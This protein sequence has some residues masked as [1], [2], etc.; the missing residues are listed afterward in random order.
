MAKKNA[1]FKKLRALISARLNVTKKMKELSVAVL[2]IR[3]KLLKI[4]AANL[5]ILYEYVISLGWKTKQK[6]SWAVRA[7]Q[8]RLT[9][10]EMVKI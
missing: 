7:M 6:L 5:Q 9:A 4:P 10:I 2:C 3:K 8:D 1:P